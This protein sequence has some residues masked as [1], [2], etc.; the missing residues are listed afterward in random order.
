VGLLGTTDGTGAAARF[1]H[2]CGIALDQTGNLYVADSDNYAIRKVTPSGVVTTIVSHS[3][4]LVYPRGLAVGSDGALYVADA[5][6]FVV[7]RVTTG[8]VVTTLA[9]TVGQSGA[10]DGS[11][12]AARFGYVWSIAAHPDGNLYLSDHE[13]HVIR[14]VT[15]AGVVT[16]L[17]GSL[18]Q[19][20]SA[21]GTGAAARFSYPWG[22]AS[23]A[24]GTLAV[25]DHGNHTIRVIE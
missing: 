8:G 24:N 25:V 11:G 15:L 1:N 20:G 22:I 19:E 9:G 12:A 18:G 17:A 6:N 21:N 5:H 10:A 7:R 13:N 3:A 16:T 23:K 2:P 14:K 4:G